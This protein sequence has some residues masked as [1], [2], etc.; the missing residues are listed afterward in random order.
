MEKSIRSL[1]HI[2]LL[3]FFIFGALHLGAS[4]LMM[5]GVDTKFT[6]IAVNVLDLPFLMAALIYG[7]TRLTMHIGDITGKV[8]LSFIVC[9]ACALVL[10]LIALYFNFIL[11]DVQ[12]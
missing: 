4:M 2:S 8:K 12:F 9:S 6:L 11:P 5:Q 7:T 10:F 3:F 1:S